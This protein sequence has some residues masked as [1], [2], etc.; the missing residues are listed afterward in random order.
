MLVKFL[1]LFLKEKALLLNCACSDQLRVGGGVGAGGH[2]G[3]V[4]VVVF[5]RKSTVVKLCVFRSVEGG[6][7]RGGMLVKFLML[8]LKEKALLLNCVVFRRPAGDPVGSRG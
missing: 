1:L 3:Q 7:G 4:F 6:W 8:F 2:V 5:E